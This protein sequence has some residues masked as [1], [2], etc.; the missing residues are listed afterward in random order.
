MIAFAISELPAET[1]DAAFA[2]IRR[3]VN[4]VDAIDRSL[5]SIGESIVVDEALEQIA[6]IFSMVITPGCS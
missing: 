6:N 3:V 2:E 1:R 4:E 5:E